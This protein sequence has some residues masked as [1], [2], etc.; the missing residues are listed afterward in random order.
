MKNIPILSYIKRY[1]FML[2]ILAVLIYAYK[3]GSIA[4]A[5]RGALLVPIFIMICAASVLLL[6]NVLNRKTTDPYVD[7][8]DWLKRD[9]ADLTPFQRVMLTK[10]EAAAYF[11]GASLIAA[12]LL[13]L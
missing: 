6:R 13:A 7:D 12:S 2:V 5:L 8:K 1:W 11:I 4:L 9:W 10:A 3:S